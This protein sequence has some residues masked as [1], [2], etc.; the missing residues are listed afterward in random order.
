MEAA[1]HEW[2]KMARTQLTLDN[3]QRTTS[4]EGFTLVEIILAVL[5][6]AIAI[7]PIVSA[8]GPAI[9]STSSEEERAVFTN[10]V[11]GTLSRVMAL[12]FTTLDS[13]QGDPVNLATLFGTQAEADKETF[14]FKGANYTPTVA[15]TDASGGPGGLLELTVTL[16]YVSLKTLKTEH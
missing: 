16:D 8:F 4:T 1:R 2:T 14:S 7:V 9:L 12:D 10:Q 15:V 6:L 5:L 11:R 13:N 3:G